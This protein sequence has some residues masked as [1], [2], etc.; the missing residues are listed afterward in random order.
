MN[1]ALL[2]ISL[3]NT[4]DLPV[5]PQQLFKRELGK[6]SCS[7][8]TRPPG[9]DAVQIAPQILILLQRAERKRRG[10]EAAGC[11]WPTPNLWRKAGREEEGGEATCGAGARQLC[12]H[13]CL[14]HL[15]WSQIRTCG[16]TLTYSLKTGLI[17][18]FQQD[19]TEPW[20]LPQH[21]LLTWNSIAYHQHLCR[22]H[23][24]LTH[25]PFITYHYPS[26]LIA[27]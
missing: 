1:G 2:H 27:H 8:G 22:S 13:L 18:P 24:Q 19:R 15:K 26:L 21:P 5:C 10:R 12:T 14:C 9:S 17:E 20:P 25:L 23:W 11:I 16:C 3:L 6:P 7:A 4:S